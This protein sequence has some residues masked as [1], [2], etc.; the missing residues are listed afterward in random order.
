MF[1]RKL[2]KA[3]AASFT[4]ALPKDW[5]T[6][7]DLKKGDIIYVNKISNTE[8]LVSTELKSDKSEKREITLSLDYKRLDSLHRELTSAYINNYSTINIIGKELYKHVSEI[9]SFFS[10]F[11][12]MEISEQTSS[13]IIAKDMLDLREVSIDKTIRRMDIIVR[14]IIKDLIPSDKEMAESIS[15][16]DQDVN[17]L[18]FLLFKIIKTSLKQ[19]DTAKIIGIENYADILSLW[20]LI[21]NLENISDNAKEIYSISIDVKKEPFFKDLIPLY[22]SIEKAYLEVMKSYYH[23]DKNLADDV[24]SKRKSIF[25][26]CIGISEKYNITS[27]TKITED[28][29]E[30]ENHIC[31]IARVV[32][33]RE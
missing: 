21:L 33:D 6:T 26:N 31:N 29:K 8:L 7:N 14:S 30:I 12:A 2:V 3:G 22:E 1:I 9:R 20:Y 25:E 10:D 13:K 32:L 28:I 23:N 17:R 24:A 27:V 15:F 19:P 16:R 4:V 18:Y 11:I 5:I